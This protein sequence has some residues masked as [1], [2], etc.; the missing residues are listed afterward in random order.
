[1]CVNPYLFRSLEIM[2]VIDVLKQ[3]ESFV[4][5]RLSEAQ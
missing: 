3:R 5:D 4:V 2:Q 1:M